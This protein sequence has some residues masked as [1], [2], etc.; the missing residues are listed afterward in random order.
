MGGATRCN[1]RF[2]GHE[3]NFNPRSPWGERPL[4][5]SRILIRFLFQ[6]TLPVGGATWTVTF[7]PFQFCISI[8][9][10]RGGS[11]VGLLVLLQIIWISI[12]APRGGSD[13][14]SYKIRLDKSDFNPRSPWGERPI[15]F[16]CVNTLFNFNPRSPWGERRIAILRYA[17]AIRISIHAPRGG[18]DR[19][20]ASFKALVQNFNPRSPWGERLIVCVAL[21]MGAVFQSTLPVG[22]ATDMTFYRC[23][24]FYNFNPRSP[25]G[26][27]PFGAGSIPVC[28]HFN[29]RS[30]W[31]ERRFR[32]FDC[33]GRKRI[34][35]H[36]PR[37]GSDVVSS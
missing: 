3:G 20:W 10:P 25:W 19:V 26:E 7:R 30:P 9:A 1:A 23:M 4:F 24:K 13:D 14:G 31:G 21:F 36:A 28:Y 12:H 37:G 35:I 8:H 11:D 33:S 15:W 16:F 34:S 18:S 17:L 27:R 6:S 2:A 22:G 32:W 29:P 5:S